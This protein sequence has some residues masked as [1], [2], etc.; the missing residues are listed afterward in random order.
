VKLRGSQCPW[1][2]A[3]PPP[4]WRQ[5][6]PGLQEVKGSH[7]SWCHCVPLHY[8]EA[9]VSQHHVPPSSHRDGLDAACGR[10]VGSSQASSLPARL[11][12][13]LLLLP[14]PPPRR[15]HAGPVPQPL[16]H[17]A[18][19][20]WQMGNDGRVPW[21]CPPDHHPSTG[22]FLALALHQGGSL[23][24]PSFPNPLPKGKPHRE[25]TLGTNRYPE[26]SGACP[27]AGAKRSPVLFCTSAKVAGVKTRHRASSQFLIP[28]FQSLRTNCI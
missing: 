2:R 6:V 12:G 23:L 26:A 18:A 15:A 14:L 3:L 21:P 25:G 1:A 5:P 13:A 9:W 10:P 27:L 7:A 11:V 20:A 8:C 24:T 22:L 4:C 17:G 28:M 16:A 19:A